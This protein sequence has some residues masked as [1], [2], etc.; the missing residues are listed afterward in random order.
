M[1]D[2][3]GIDVSK[4]HLDLYC[5]DDGRSAR[6]GNDAAGFRKLKAWLP[7]AGCIARIFVAVMSHG[8]FVSHGVRHAA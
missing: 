1:K 3:I 5:L 4:D 2:S 7:D 8:S 6:F